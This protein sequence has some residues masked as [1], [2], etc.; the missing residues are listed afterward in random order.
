M[1]DLATLGS[2]YA[3]FPLLPPPGLRTMHNTHHATP[4]ASHTLTPPARPLTWDQATSQALY[5]ARIA[6]GSLRMAPKAQRA[7]FASARFSSGATNGEREV[8]AA[9]MMQTCV[10]GGG[11]GNVG[12]DDT[13]EGEGKGCACAHSR[14][15][16]RAF[17]AA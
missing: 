15:H 6:R 12:G 5:A 17:W 10:C 3:P 1:R 2:L 16:Q 9:A 8:M 4:A 7:A 11:E 14:L 13:R